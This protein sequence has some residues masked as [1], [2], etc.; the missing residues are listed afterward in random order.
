MIWLLACTSSPLDSALDSQGVPRASLQ[1][2]FPLLEREL[3]TETAGVDHDPA[4]YEGIE[5]LICTAYDGRNFPACYDEHKGSDYML[6]GGF[7]TMDAGSASVLAAADGVVLSVEDGH[8]DRCHGD[9][10]T[11]QNDCDG[12]EMTANHVVLEHEGGWTTRY[13]HLMTDSVAVEPGQQVAC[14]EVLGKVGSSGNSSA[15]HLHFELQDASGVDVDPYAG[16]HSQD[17]TFWVE[18]GEPEH[19]PGSACP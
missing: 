9:A 10:S 11:F 13:W 19:L 15:P 18:Q 7:D 6:E 8:Y 1:L 3:F 12:H 2:A 16:E 17:Q 14:G 4:V 5:Q